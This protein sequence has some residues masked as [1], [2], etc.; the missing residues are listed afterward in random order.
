MRGALLV[1]HDENDREVPIACGEAIARAWPGAEL[2][3]T[4]GLG[5]Q[6]ILR[7]AATLKRVV[8]FV[9]QNPRGGLESD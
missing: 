4:R 3:R 2:V 9:A 5:H 8:R 1:V 7:D 6:R